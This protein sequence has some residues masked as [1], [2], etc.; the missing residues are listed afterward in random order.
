M[1]ATISKVST[2]KRGVGFFLTLVWFSYLLLSPIYVFPKGLP[3][4]A[5][6]ILLMGLLP[7]IALFFL[8]SSGK[9]PFMFF[10]GSV[11]AI[12]TFLVNVINFGFLP[13]T[14][15]LLSAVY[16]PYNFLVFCLVTYLF[17]KDYEGMVKITYI[18]IVVTV[19]I[20]YLWAEFFPDAGMKRVTAGF[21][22]PNQLAYWALLT[23]GMIFFLRRFQRF[24]RL[25]LVMFALLAIIQTLALSK[26]GIISCGI[27]FV[28]LF[29]T[30]QVSKRAKFVLFGLALFLAAYFAANPRILINYTTN[31]DVVERVSDRLGTIGIENDD[32]AEG[33]GY[34]RIF[35]NPEYLVV[36][37]GEGGFVR[38]RT[39]ASSNELHSGLATIIFSYGVLGFAIFAAFIGSIFYRQPKYTWVIIG[40]IL[41]F[42]ITHQAFRFT[43]F[44]VFLAIAYTTF[45]YGFPVGASTQDYLFF[46]KMREK[47]YSRLRGA[48]RSRS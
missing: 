13:D 22:N 10:V 19:F 11:F 40:C 27:L 47:D 15:F 25:D 4:P 1:S 18:G 6:L 36:G 26:A 48:S 39:W 44:W 46:Q 16:Y 31:L 43:H 12:L 21:L 8:D 37:A 41:L 17:K 2:D 5:D 3:Q 34:N 7:G 20:Q 29:F 14:R 42:S 35:N 9:I 23:A 33:R 30:P 38:F 32:S 45:R 28:Y 24:S